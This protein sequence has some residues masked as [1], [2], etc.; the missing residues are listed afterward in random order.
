MADKTLGTF[1]IDAELWEGF[2]EQAR[3]NG[4]NAS[5]L[6][7]AWI[8]AYLDKSIDASID[9][10]DKPMISLEEALQPILQRLDNLETELG[11]SKA[12]SVTPAR[13]GSNLNSPTKTAL[14]RQSCAVAT[15]STRSMSLEQLDRVLLRHKPI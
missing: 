11:K 10:I 2:K 8:S 13:P 6:I 5:S 9:S 12:W 4:T 14:V 1:R 7:I 3:S 15:T